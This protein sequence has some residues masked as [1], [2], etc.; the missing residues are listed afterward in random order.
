[1]P[2]LSTYGFDSL[3]GATENE[4]DCF[5]VPSH[6]VVEFFPWPGTSNYTFPR[7]NVYE[8]DYSGD[9]YSF[10]RINDAGHKVCKIN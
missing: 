4:V 9:R 6:R 10:E 1:M 5:E 2:D 3:P 7:G 8:F